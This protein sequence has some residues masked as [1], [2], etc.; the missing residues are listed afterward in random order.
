[1]VM[2]IKRKRK[3]C[4]NTYEN[5]AQRK[6]MVFGLRPSGPACSS[7]SLQQAVHSNGRQ[8]YADISAHIGCQT[9][10]VSRAVNQ[11]TGYFYPGKS[12]CILI[13]EAHKESKDV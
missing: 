1:M 12:H 2:D 10:T 7:L 5:I 6:D 9:L 8:S 4:E 13:T 3:T 11:V